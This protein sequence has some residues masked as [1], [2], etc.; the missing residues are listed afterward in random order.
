MARPPGGDRSHGFEALA[1]GAGGVV[2]LLLW[3]GN[4]QQ[5]RVGGRAPGLSPCQL[6]LRTVLKSAA[7]RAYPTCLLP[8]LCP[9]IAGRLS[10]VKGSLVS[11]GLF[12]PL[13]QTLPRALAAPVQQQKPWVLMGRFW[14]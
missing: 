1:R 5:V 4:Q 12:G 10:G 2:T 14:K 8:T 9:E 3:L 6:I 13:P 11:K 7:L